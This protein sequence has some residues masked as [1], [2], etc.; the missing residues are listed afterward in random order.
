M[1]NANDG[2]PPTD[3]PRFLTPEQHA[4]AQRFADNAADAIVAI[5]ATI[6]GA[7]LV[8]DALDM[9]IASERLAPVCLGEIAKARRI[10]GELRDQIRAARAEVGR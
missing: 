9:L 10:A 2:A 7:Q 5:D 8:V 4:L 3:A 6:G 1:P